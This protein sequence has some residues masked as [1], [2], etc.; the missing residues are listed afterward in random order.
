MSSLL[1]CRIHTNHRT[2]GGDEE[3][4]GGAEPTKGR[5]RV[6]DIVL[7]EDENNQLIIPAANDPRVDTL[8]KCKEVIALFLRRHYSESGTVDQSR[9]GLTER[10][11]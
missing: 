8:P 10:R 3:A 11:Q 6:P 2:T 4:E 5:K 9:R 1:N 7:D